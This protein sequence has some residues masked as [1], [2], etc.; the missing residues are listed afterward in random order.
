MQHAFTTNEQRLLRVGACVI[1]AEWLL[2]AAAG[3]FVL[4]VVS[5]GIVTRSSY[6]CLPSFLAECFIIGTGFTLHL[7]SS[8]S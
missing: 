7:D 2:S 4:C 3:T 8:I 6:I 1:V 5:Y